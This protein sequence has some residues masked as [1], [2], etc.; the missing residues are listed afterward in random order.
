MVKMDRNFLELAINNDVASEEYPR[1]HI[2]LSTNG[3]ECLRS[4]Q[5]SWR[6]AYKRKIINR[7]N[8]LF[9]VGHYGEDDIINE[10]ESLGCI[11]TDRQLIIPSLA[12]HWGGSIDGIIQL[13]NEIRKSLLEIKTHN[14][15]NFN[16]LVKHGIKK[17][18]PKHYDQMQAYMSHEGI[19]KQA[20][21]IAI[22]KN[23]SAVAVLY[24][25]LD[26]ERAN[27]LKRYRM[28]V[29]SSD[30]LLPRIKGASEE[31][32]KCKFCEA[33]EV[34]WRD[35]PIQRNCRT[36]N[37]V[38]ILDAGKWQCSIDER[39]LSIEDQIKGCK[40]YTLDEKYFS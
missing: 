32:Y 24:V 4:L 38:D 33:S 1:S 36:C 28:E 17:A 5:F 7:M 21:Y 34:C 39:F 11:I 35:E 25:E 18:F 31:Y 8:R 15:K 6:W 12:G 22:N 26:Q 14:Q 23:N 10:L 3:T 27:E 29:I 19:P 2:G 40:K 37:H 13:P 9:R 20:V 16:A 30:T